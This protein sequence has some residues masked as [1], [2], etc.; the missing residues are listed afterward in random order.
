M[1]GLGD[2]AGGS[3]FSLALAINSDGSVLVGRGSSASG[4]EAFRW[5][6]GT[7]MV[8]LGDLA[9]GGFFS[10]ALGVNAD[11]SV[12]V[13]TGSSASGNEAFRWTEAG[14]MIRVED[15]LSNA[16]VGLGNFTILLS[17]D[18]I[19]DDGSVI[20]GGG[21]SA[22]GGEAF[23]ARVSS[24]G[25][26]I[27]D[28]ASLPETLTSTTL[29]QTVGLTSVLLPLFGAHHKPLMMYQ[30]L[31][32]ANCVWATSDIAY[33]DEVFSKTIYNQ[34]VGACHNFIEDRLKAGLG[35]GYTTVSQ[36]TSFGG[37][38]DFKI[39]YGIAEANYKPHNKNTIFS[40]TGLY[41][42]GDVDIDRG[43]L[44]GA[45][46]DSSNS[47]TDIMNYALK[48]AVHVPNFLKPKIQNYEFSMTPH[49][50]YTYAYSKADGY[51]EEGGGFPARFDEQD[52]SYHEVRGGA[53]VATVI[54]QNKTRLGFSAELIYE[55]E[56]D[57]SDVS[58]ELIGLFPFSFD[59][60]DSG[61]DLSMRLGFEIEHKINENLFI[62]GS[63]FVATSGRGPDISGA[64][65][66]KYSF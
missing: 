33:D 32:N 25:S 61:N 37:D 65:G 29:S 6:S 39:P 22:S 42:L 9:G 35:V 47:E 17:A 40:L 26:G 18:G 31:D 59:S 23:L 34:E 53:E 55:L 20:V 4:F 51:T 63:S 27:L 24:V 13:G 30:G 48:A 3:F 46:L 16:G 19:S 12:I 28:T 15:W 66:L 43:Y 56:S 58:G 49:F 54:N 45:A 14:G 7:G 1:V 62:D 50:S 60:P 44:N 41:G 64:I 2:L 36:D 10:Q 8:G 52:A 21:I 11:G 38:Q 5:T 57:D